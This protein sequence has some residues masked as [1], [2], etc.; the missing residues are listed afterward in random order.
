[1]SKTAAER[2]FNIFMLEFL[3][4][5]SPTDGCTILGAFVGRWEASME[6]SSANCPSPQSCLVHKHDLLSLYDQAK[7][8]GRQEAKK[9]WEEMK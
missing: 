2:E 7:V 4:S 1:M 5:I 3:S 9:I 6:I 8:S